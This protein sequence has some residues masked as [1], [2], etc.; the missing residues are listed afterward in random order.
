M[1]PDDAWHEPWRP[2]RRLGAAALLGLL[3]LAAV[4]Y[5]LTLGATGWVVPGAL[6]VVAAA[7]IGRPRRDRVLHLDWRGRWVSLR[8]AP[9]SMFPAWDPVLS[10]WTR[11]DVRAGLV[12]AGVDPVAAVRFTEAWD[13][14]RRIRDQGVPWPGPAAHRATMAITRS[15]FVARNEARW[16]YGALVEAGGEVRVC[17]TPETARVLTRTV[18]AGAVLVLTGYATAHEPILAT[19]LP[20][21]SLAL[22]PFDPFDT[23][24]LGMAHHGGP[25][26]P[27]EV[28]GGVDV[29]VASLGG[30]G[31]RRKCEIAAQDRADVPEVDECRLDGRAVSDRE[32]PATLA[33]LFA[34]R[35]VGG[36]RTELDDR[37]VGVL[38]RWR[39]RGENDG[40]WVNFVQAWLTLVHCPNGGETW[41]FEGWPEDL[42]PAFRRERRPDH[43]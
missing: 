29:L 32:W 30:K 16:P 20:L 10:G 37:V 6:G 34:Y 15:L 40:A 5:G 33:A 35:A 12:R 36:P 8:D 19:R 38:R 9:P 31:S 18:P 7:W 1:T 43:R 24:V 21:V 13:A 42:A 25:L 23:E 28:G 3:G 14:A 17:P 22:C 26:A 41:V 39:E 11:E 2:P 27:L 4:G